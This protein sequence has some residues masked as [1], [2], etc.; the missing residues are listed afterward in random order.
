MVCV[1]GPVEFRM[2]SP[3]HEADRMR[4]EIPHPRCIGRGFA[5]ASKPVTFGQWAR[6]RNENP[7]AFGA[8]EEM[9]PGEHLPMTFVSWMMAAGYCNWL[10]QKEGIAKGQWCHPRRSRPA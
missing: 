5:L 2:G 3:H 7:R 9:P 4:N 10:S 6:Y 1:R 8:L